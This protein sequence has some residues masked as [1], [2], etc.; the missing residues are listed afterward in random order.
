MLSYSEENPSWRDFHSHIPLKVSKSE[1]Q[2]A[3]IRAHLCC[4]TLTSAASERQAGNVCERL[5]KL[6]TSQAPTFG[7]PRL[8]LSSVEMISAGG[9]LLP[10][11]VA[12]N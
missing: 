12:D 6:P 8:G 10:L 2:R 7:V 11:A 4:G 5:E 9:F 3:V 1:L